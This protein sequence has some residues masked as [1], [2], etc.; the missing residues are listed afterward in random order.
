MIVLNT[1]CETSNNKCD[2]ENENKKSSSYAESLNNDKITAEDFIKT[3]SKPRISYFE[4]R[5]SVRENNSFNNTNSA[6][7]KPNTA[8]PPINFYNSNDT[9]PV[10][11]SSFTLPEYDDLQNKKILSVTTIDHLISQYILPASDVLPLKSLLKTTNAESNEQKSSK[12]VKFI[13][14]RHVCYFEFDNMDPDRVYLKASDSVR[15]ESLVSARAAVIEEKKIQQQET[16]KVA[17]NNQQHVN[18]NELP[19]QN[20]INDI[21]LWNTSWLK[22]SDADVVKVNGEHSVLLPVMQMFRSFE[23]YERV[24]IP[25]MKQE[26]WISMRNYYDT[27]KKSSQNCVVRHVVNTVAR[28]NGFRNVYSCLSKFLYFNLF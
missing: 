14:G 24:M 7:N 2:S 18:V 5:N 6:S 12:K 16:S 26:L 28:G 3:S 19:H 8:V 20:I 4:R 23:D 27:A 25:L 15:K 22:F 13:E 11:S 21:T 17:Q 9:H 10:P 1:S